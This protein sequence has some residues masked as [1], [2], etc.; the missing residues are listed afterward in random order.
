MF[1][2]V[3]R[4][5]CGGRGG[6]SLCK[7]RSQ[8]ARTFRLMSRG[9]EMRGE[10][11]APR[12]REP[13]RFRATDLLFSPRAFASRRSAGTELSDPGREFCIWIHTVRA[14]ALYRAIGEPSHS[15]KAP[16]ALVM[17]LN[18]SARSATYI[19]LLPPSSPALDSRHVIKANDD[20]ATTIVSA[21]NESR[22]PGFVPF[23]FPFAHPSPP[24][25]SRR[26]TLNASLSVPSSSSARAVITSGKLG[27]IGACEPGPGCAPVGQY[28]FE[29]L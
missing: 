20:N 17:A 11:S 15:I 18:G 26:P 27:E 13:G 9:T 5:S 7:N 23:P 29:F 28:S 2:H 3:D 6:S 25:S 24:G 21:R 8:L 1:L 19:K 16:L 12:K 22:K 4:D 14:G 10:V